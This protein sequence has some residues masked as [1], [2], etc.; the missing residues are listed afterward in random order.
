MEDITG[1]FLGRETTVHLFL[2][3]ADGAVPAEK[4]YERENV[5]E[6]HGETVLVV[7]DDKEVRS[8]V[9][10]MLKGLNYHVI[11]TATAVE[12]IQELEE[13]CRVDV[14]LS[15]IGLPGGMNGYELAAAVRSEYPEIKI[16]F[17]SGYDASKFPKDGLNVPNNT[18]LRKPFSRRKLSRLIERLITKY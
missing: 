15:D 12:A 17:I 11:E 1:H 13:V 5:F 7:E 18:L 4:R 16:G 6:G 9:V 10:R 8:L 2:P 14:V 3:T